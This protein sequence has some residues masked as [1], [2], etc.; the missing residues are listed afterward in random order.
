MAAGSSLAAEQCVDQS[1]LLCSLR[2]YDC[3]KLKTVSALC[4]K[5]CGACGGKP[6]ASKSQIAFILVFN[7]AQNFVLAD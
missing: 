6:A 2:K 5:T 1:Q 4:R 3:G 7:S